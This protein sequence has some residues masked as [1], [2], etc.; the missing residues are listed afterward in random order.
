VDG[1]F[2]FFSG[3]AEEEDGAYVAVPAGWL[4][5]I[6]T[7]ILSLVNGILRRHGTGFEPQRAS[8]F[9]KWVKVP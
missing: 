1:A 5:W 7:R 3:F 8:A 4:F 9:R 6:L 2:I